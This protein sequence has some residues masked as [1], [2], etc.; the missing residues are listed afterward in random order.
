MGAG[1]SRYADTADT[2]EGDTVATPLSAAKMLTELKRAGL[3]IQEYKSWKTHNRNHKGAWGPV[4][5]V[6]IHHTVSS[7]DDSSVALCYNGHSTLPG[8]L[9][10]AVGRNDGRIALVGH[11]RAN[12]AGMGDDGVLDAVVDE[13]A[14]PSVN[15]A[16]KDGNR[17][18]YGLEIVNLG[19]NKDTYTAKQYRSAVLWAAA[20]CRAHGWNER[21]VI[22]HKEWQP[23]KIDP[24]GPVEGKGAFSMG[25]FRSDVKAQLAAWKNPAPAPKPQTPAPPP[26]P[27][28]STGNPMR[29]TQL[30]RPE[31]LVIPAGGDKIVYFTAPD[32]RDDPNEH[33]AGGYTVLS[34]P[35]VYTGTVSVWADAD[36]V[37]ELTVKMVQ[38]T[39]S[40]TG[41]SVSSFADTVIE[42]GE[43]A[44][45]SVTGFL[46]ED[47][48]LRVQITNT[49]SVSVTLPR[50][51][52][53]LISFAE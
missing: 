25:T 16:N 46:P 23:G 42:P 8:P 49:G 26:A 21:S 6:M 36:N 35:A 4:Y 40:P 34:S 1:C 41:P 31:P 27:A 13:R 47:R 12:H 2:T 18:F 14:L 22:G 52:I 5:G 38:E 50:V 20:I 11:G 43:V 30:S 9:C 29:Y 24:R 7:A 44:S 10:H 32:V 37:A 15:E 45:E 28:P 51:D 33:G 17:H 39:V 53:R 3:V 19:D 48:K